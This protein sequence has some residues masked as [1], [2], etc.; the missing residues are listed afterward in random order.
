APEPWGPW[1]TV[2]QA[3]PWDVAPGESCSFPTKW[4]NPDG[5]TLYL[6]FSG[7]DAFSV[8]R[9][10]LRVAADGN[11]PSSRLARFRP[12]RR[13][14]ERPDPPPCHTNCTFR[15]SLDVTAA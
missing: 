10:T 9:A 13:R 14:R 2:Y 8:R 5:T 7:G 6:V 12:R 3:D 4:M 11:E 1:T 15:N